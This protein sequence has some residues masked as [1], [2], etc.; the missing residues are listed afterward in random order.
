M[1]L[2]FTQGDSH[3]WW[4]AGAT[5][6]GIVTTV[7]DQSSVNVALPTIANHFNADLPSVQWVTAGYILTTSVLLL[8]MGRLSDVLGRKR[9]FVMGFLVFM[10]SALLAGSAN[11]LLVIIVAKVFQGVGSAMIQATSMAII[12]SAFG[13][14]QRGTALGMNNTAV[15]IGSITGPILGG[16]LITALGWPPSFSSTCRWGSSA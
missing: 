7:V 6:L 5:G 10:L 9:V 1:R 14:H 15:G 11:S 16:F 2:A 3:K 13:S 12:I 8:P 4:V